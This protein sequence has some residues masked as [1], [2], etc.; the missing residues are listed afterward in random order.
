MAVCYVEAF[1]LQNAFA[2]AG[3]LW[4]AAV[5]RGGRISPLRILLG[6]ALGTAWALAAAMIGGALRGA[7]VQGAVSGLMV[8]TALGTRP[9]KETL[10]SMGMLWVGAAAL[11]GLAALGM[12]IVM[13]G[14]ATGLGGLA[15]LRRKH[16]MPP[17]AVRLCIRQK[18]TA[19]RMEAVVDTGNRAIDPLTCLPVV[20]IPTG[21]FAADEGRLLCI[22]TAA[23]IRMMPC[24]I[25][26]AVWINGKAVRAVVA[27]APAGYLDSALV[28]WSLCAERMAS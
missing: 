24:F 3:L 17:P 7:A 20:F 27:L 8:W 10:Q 14:A 12:P 5:W 13:A 18:D 19:R 23:G 16:T 15:L 21:A 28:P 9:G 25:P 4:L 2:D 6:A 22:R 26:D 11:G 1:V